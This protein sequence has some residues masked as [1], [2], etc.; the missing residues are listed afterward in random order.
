MNHLFKT[1]VVLAAAG[2][3]S[4]CATD[5]T[6]AR[7]PCVNEPGGW[8][9]FTRDFAVR[10]WDYSQL[11]NDAY[12]DEERFTALPEGIEL[13]R[14]S[15]NDGAGLAYTIYDRKQ[16]GVLAERIIAFRG[17]EFSFADW[18]VGNIEGAQNDRGAL[19]YREV[20]SELD[21]EGHE[22]VSIRVTG[23]SLGGAI[24][25]HIALNTDKV[26]SYA[27]NQ[28]PRFETPP[29]PA[30][31]QRLAVSERGEALG[32]LRG[33]F[34][35]TPQDTLVINCRPRGAPWKD[36]SI[37]RL[38]ECLTW[39]AAYDDPRAFASVV[40]NHIGKPWVECGDRDDPHPGPLASR[41]RK[42]GTPPCYQKPT[43]RGRK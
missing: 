43:I 9:G 42:A 21:T 19:V 20:R 6:Q 39:I 15:D 11:S 31:S 16:D 12:D 7:S 23:H 32:G 22:N 38:S 27:F 14:K 4:A 3:L 37:R 33:L 30:D 8:C 1:L 5:L 10:T 36:H 26:D 34:R 2:T 35:N 25:A 40:A 18:F 29:M 24:A 41:K 17:T 13:V 28:S